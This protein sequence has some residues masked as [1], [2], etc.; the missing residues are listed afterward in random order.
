MKQIINQLFC[1]IV[2][3]NFIEIRILTLTYFFF[4]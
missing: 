3:D 4:Q 2:L 1:D